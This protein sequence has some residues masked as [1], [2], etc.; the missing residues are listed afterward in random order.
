MQEELIRTQML[1]GSAAMEKLAK[2]RV[3]VFGI[4][5]VGGAASEALVR[6]GIGAIDL[7]DNDTISITNINRQIYATQDTVGQ[8]KTDVAAQ[9]ILQINPTV[10][11]RTHKVFYLPD[12]APAFDLTQYDY[13]IDAVDT[14]SA[15]IELIV[16]A[17]LAKTPIISSMGTGNKLD[18]TAFVVTDLSKTKVCPLA[19]IM[20]RE[21]KQHGIHHLQVV[22]SEEVPITPKNSVQ[23]S[24]PPGSKRP[25]QIPGSV[26]F[27]PPVAGW[28]LAGAVI[29]DLIRDVCDS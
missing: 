22:Y 7:I 13:I 25:K 27:V 24:T 14:V 26:A 5:G 3:A 23:A 28:I 18:P 11:V 9:R 8:Y 17:N 21:L 19:R 16:N 4:G 10:V 6:S 29:K 20:R 1:L 2:S 15:K 12:T